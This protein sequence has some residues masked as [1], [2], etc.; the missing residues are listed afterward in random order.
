MSQWLFVSNSD[1][2]LQEELRKEAKTMAAKNF[3]DCLIAT[4]A[5]EISKTDTVSYKLAIGIV[6]DLWVNAG[7]NRAIAV[8]QQLINT[9]EAETVKQA[10]KELADSE[11]VPDIGMYN[12]VNEVAA[13][14][15]LNPKECLCG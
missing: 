14:C 9:L 11:L 15:N 2:V 12:F 7:R 13:K 8:L 4:H 5:D 10:I 3:S 6:Y 1:V